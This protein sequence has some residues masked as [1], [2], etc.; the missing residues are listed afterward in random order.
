MA[1]N[2]TPESW[3]GKPIRQVPTYPDSES[4]AR[5]EATLRKLPPLVFAGE[6][7]RL[8]EDLADVAEGR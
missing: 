7:R 3:K 5:V 6:A 4:L 1:A 2:W 8:R